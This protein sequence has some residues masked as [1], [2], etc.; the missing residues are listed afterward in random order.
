MIFLQTTILSRF[1]SRL[2]VTMTNLVWDDDDDRQLHSSLMFTLF[3]YYPHKNIIVLWYC[4]IISSYG[5][6][7]THDSESV[8]SLIG[9]NLS[10]PHTSGKNGT[11]VMFTK[12]YVEIQINGT[13]GMRSQKFTFKNQV[14]TYKY[15]QMCV[16]HTNNY[17]SSLLTLHIRL[18]HAFI[19][20]RITRVVSWRS[21]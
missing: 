19:T 18:V 3:A 2:V 7:G 4:F 12:V 17:H 6:C 14:I 13:S 9:V 5:Y 8:L 11:S 10:E 20:W 15:F 1:S 16:H 21:M